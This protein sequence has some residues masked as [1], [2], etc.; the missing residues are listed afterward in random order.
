MRRLIRTAPTYQIAPTTTTPTMNYSERALV[1]ANVALI[2]VVEDEHEHQ[3]PRATNAA[4][5]GER[6]GGDAEDP[7]GPARDSH[8]DFSRYGNTMPAMLTRR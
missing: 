8:T 7:L 4:H 1:T 5:P 6:H 3:P 2:V